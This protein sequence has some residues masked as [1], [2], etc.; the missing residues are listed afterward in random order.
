MGYVIMRR[1]QEYVARSGAK[2]SY[3][4]KFQEARVWRTREAAQSECCGDEAVLAITD[5]LGRG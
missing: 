3:T 4:H 1:D 2:S 5:I